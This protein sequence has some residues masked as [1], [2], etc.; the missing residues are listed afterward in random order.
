MLRTALRRTAVALVLGTLLNAASPAPAA[1]R[2]KNTPAADKAPTA[3]APGLLAAILGVLDRIWAPTG[4][5]IDPHGG[6]A[7]STADAPP[8]PD[9]QDNGCYIDPHGCTR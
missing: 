3:A 7:A 5:D 6:C 8:A 1:P 2:Q 9:H 4:C